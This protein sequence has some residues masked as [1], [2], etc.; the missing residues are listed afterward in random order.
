MCA[1]YS[2]TTDKTC[3]HFAPLPYV[4]C[5]KIALL[6]CLY[7]VHCCIEKIVSL[8]TQYYVAIQ[9]LSS[10]RHILNETLFCNLCLFNYLSV[11]LKM[12]VCLSHV[13]VLISEG[14]ATR[15]FFFSGHM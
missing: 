15:T 11:E 5:T 4:C 13:E 10:L 6:L 2:V 1:L 8:L 9:G 3:M 7:V 12:F 14:M